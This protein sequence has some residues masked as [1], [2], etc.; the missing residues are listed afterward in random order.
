[1]RMSAGIN[2]VHLDTRGG[3][4]AVANYHGPDTT[5]ED[6]GTAGVSTLKVRVCGHVCVAMVAMRVAMRV[7][8]RV[9]MCADDAYVHALDT[10]FGDA[11]MRLQTGYAVGDAD[12][13]FQIV[14]TA[15]D[16]PNAS[17][18]RISWFEMGC[19]C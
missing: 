19:H 1:M 11:D 6:D 13:R 16:A 18:K 10:P 8:M 9:D 7:D 4:M 12:A 2:P 5:T 17:P 15:G 14:Y 3:V